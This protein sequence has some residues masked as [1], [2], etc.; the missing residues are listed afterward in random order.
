KKCAFFT[1]S[2]L[3]NDKYECQLNLDHDDINK[4]EFLIERMTSEFISVA[5]AQDEKETW[6]DSPLE[7]LQFILKY[8][9]ENSVQNIVILL[10]IFLTIA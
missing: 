2:N 10:R 9:L 5:A 3:L 4:E 7:L 8:H 6:K 1:P